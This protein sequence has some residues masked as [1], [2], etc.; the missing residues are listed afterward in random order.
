MKFLQN[1]KGNLM[2]GLLA[3]MFVKMYVRGIVFLDRT[4]NHYL[5]QIQSC[6]VWVKKIGKKLQKMF[7]K[8][9]LKNQ[10]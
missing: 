2:I 3:V 5:T 1:L 10:L 7:L 9:Y 6:W 4:K 8:K